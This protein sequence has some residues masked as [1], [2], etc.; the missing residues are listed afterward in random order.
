MMTVKDLKKFV[1]KAVKEN[2]SDAVVI[3]HTDTNGITDI[4][5]DK[6]TAEWKKISNGEKIFIMGK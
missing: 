3:V 2:F 1:D 6:S 4:V 5:I